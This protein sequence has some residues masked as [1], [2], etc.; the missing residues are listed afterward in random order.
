MQLWLGSL[1]Y[2]ICRREIKLLEETLCLQVPFFE[3]DLFDDH[4]LIA[5]QMKTK[6]VYNYL[7]NNVNNSVDLK[8]TNNN[9]HDD[10]EPL[11]K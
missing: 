1:K 2:L 10:D 11:L 4:K 6:C 8:L 7:Y 5:A 3:D 9:V